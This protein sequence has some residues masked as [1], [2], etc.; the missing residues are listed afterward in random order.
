MNPKMLLCLALNMFNKVI[1]NQVH[2]YP[3]ETETRSYKFIQSSLDNAPHIST[4]KSI[5]TGIDS[6]LIGEINYFCI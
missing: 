4:L 3:N 1:I 2:L 6:C 5:S